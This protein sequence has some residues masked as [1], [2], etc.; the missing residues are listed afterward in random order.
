MATLLVGPSHAKQPVKRH[1]I[2]R[3]GKLLP[4]IVAAMAILT[5]ASGL[6]PLTWF[7]FSDY[8]IARQVRNTTGPF[9]PNL[10]LQVPHFVGSGALAGN[11]TPTETFPHRTFT[12][13]S[14]GFR[15][16]PTV[17][18]GGPGVVVLRGFSFTWG[19]GLSDEQTFPA[20]LARQL[21]EN[22]YD[23]ARFHE[24]QESPEDFD[25]LMRQ[26]GAAPKTTVYVH[27]EPN[28]H[29]FSW[30]ADRKVDRAGKAILGPGAYNQVM[31]LGRF[32]YD[33]ASTWMHLSPFVLEAVRVKKAMQNDWFLPNPYRKYATIFNLPDGRRMVVRTGDVDRALSSPDE[34]TVKDRAAYIA[35]WIESLSHRGI[36]AAVLLVPD[37]ITV[38]GPELGLKLPA[39]PYLNRLERE[40]HARG[41]AV[42]NGLA[43]M[44]AN[45]PADLAS[46]RLAYFREDQHWN[47]LGVQRLAR[48]TAEELKAR[49]ADRSFAVR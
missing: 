46:G 3:P 45:A 34:A 29:V 8:E 9:M 37:S 17:K 27:L 43:P 30:Y 49:Q 11:L 2:W 48:A 33:F 4:R 38:Y 22:V 16:T 42:V 10:R 36:S 23:A 25:R 31:W 13:D 20:E 14:L 18:P 32:T 15:Y 5:A 21:G 40:L 6:L 41:I 7:P 24:D 26:L 44:R 1:S 47:F 28:A 35:W 12:T 19:A 39:D